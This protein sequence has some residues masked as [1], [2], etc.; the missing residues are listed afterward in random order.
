MRLNASLF[1]FGSLLLIAAACNNKPEATQSAAPAQSS[2]TQPMA[3]NTAS[4]SAA[5]NEQKAE[6]NATGTVAGAKI[7]VCSLIKSD[8]LQAIQGEAIKETKPNVRAAGSLLISHC[9]YI[10]PTFSKSLSLELTQSDSSKGERVN[11]KKIWEERFS[12]AEGE[13]DKGREKEREREKKE[14]GDKARGEGEESETERIEGI[15]EEAFWTGNRAL[16]ALYVF[17]KNSIL[18]LSL[19]GPEDEA[20]KI[21]KLKVLAQKAIER[22]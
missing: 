21:K 8:E 14:G 6:D 3:A 17:S 15:G 5:R 13:K 9:L 22:L 16:G 20:A 4:A 10:L 18:R 12:K 7:E 11:L 19:G 1:L 2:S